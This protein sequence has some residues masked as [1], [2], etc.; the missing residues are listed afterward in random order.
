MVVPA[1]RSGRG[2]TGFR[3]GNLGQAQLVEH[4]PHDVGA[5]RKR[6]AEGGHIA[7]LPQKIALG[8]DGLL[9]ER[10]Q[11]TS[12]VVRHFQ[13]LVIEGLVAQTRERHEAHRSIRGADGAIEQGH[14]DGLVVDEVLDTADVPVEKEVTL[15]ERL[16]GQ[17]VYRGRGGP[18]V[19]VE[20]KGVR[21]G[22]KASDE[23]RK[24]ESGHAAFPSPKDR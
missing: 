4:G 23:C 8:L 24:C 18:D 15:V 22:P 16:G 2:I 13:A 21:R 17:P 11:D 1:G 19:V 12:G 5:A 20:R 7:V 6:M 14:V 10:Y 3:L 9:Y